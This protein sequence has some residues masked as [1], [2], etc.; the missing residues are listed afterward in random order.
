M[1]VKDKALAK[2]FVVAMFFLVAFLGVF[3]FFAHSHPLV[4]YDGD[5]W[6]YLSPVRL[7]FPIWGIWNPIK[8]LPEISMPFC[9]YMAVN[10][11][12]PKVG[13]YIKSITVCSALIFSIAITIYFYLFYRL[14]DNKSDL[15]YKINLLIIFLLI[16]FHFTIF[17]NSR[18]EFIHIFH[19]ADLTC[20]FYYV[21]PALVN[22]SLVLYLFGCKD[23]FT[24]LDFKNRGFVVIWFYLAIFSN[25]YQSIILISFIFVQLSYLYVKEYKDNRFDFECIREFITKH[26]N[27]VIVIIIWL[28]SLIFEANGGRATQ[29]GHSIWSLPV[30]ETVLFL[31]SLLR[32]ISLI[33]VMVLITLCTYMVIVRRNQA[34]NTADYVYKDI[35]NKSFLCL[36]LVLVYVTL[37][38][39][40][41]FPNYAGN[42]NV[43][44]SYMFFLFVIF[45][46]AVTYVLKTFPR[47]IFIV[48]FICFLVIAHLFNTGGNFRE[49]NIRNVN[50]DKCV[51]VDKDLI[52]QIVEAEKAGKNEM[53]L[54]VP[55]GDN[56]DNW[57]HPLYM[58]YSIS[59][60]LVAHGIV[61]R[62]MK[63]KIKPDVNMNLK[64]NLNY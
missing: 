16:L 11:F 58:G 54:V 50:P 6:L 62:D 38:S 32:K 7:P 47:I 33:F 37:V 34:G 56:H 12:L 3:V 46:I 23:F 53:I 5:D 39:A 60:T 43:A 8:V 28:I 1:N 48:P 41:A 27:L 40:K 36:I 35:I 10:W 59:K 64:Y 61:S 2:S 63:I 45:G 52:G 25:I 55:K 51:L 44:I 19:S 31:I 17:Q 57:P 49:S 15:S 9:G 22:S 24:E 21:L 29:I 13:D 4:P 26:L 20:Y 30:K 42:V 18:S 14:F